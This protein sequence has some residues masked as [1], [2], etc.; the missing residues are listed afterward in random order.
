[1]AEITTHMFLSKDIKKIIKCN[2]SITLFSLGPDVFYFSKKTKKLAQIMHRKNTLLFFKNYIKYIKDNNLENDEYIVSSL[3]GFLSHYVLDFKTHPYIFYKGE[4]KLH[5]LYEMGLSKYI[6]SSHNIKPNNYKSYKDLIYEKNKTIEQLLDNVLYQ[7][8]GFNG[9]GK[10]YIKC[11]K[12]VKF[13]YRLFRYDKY[14][15]KKKIYK[16]I[17]L[18]SKNKL[19]LISFYNI[20]DVDLNINHN[21]WNH[22]C[23]KNEI[24]NSSLIDLYNESLNKTLE[25]INSV[26]MVLYKN[27]NIDTLD[28]VIENRSYINGKDSNTR[29]VMKYFEI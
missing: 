24:Y 5:R 26:N 14:G 9:Y 27:K 18:F 4:Y 7:T 28:K 29:N 16:F 17:D 3:Y 8:Y 23:D 2:K 12:R 25:I 1:M 20:K 6:I 13:T 10:K 11:L 15:I 22:P 21:K 19:S